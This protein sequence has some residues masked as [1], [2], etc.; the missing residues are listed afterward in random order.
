MVIEH[1][2]LVRKAAAKY[3]GRHYRDWVDDITQD[4]MLKIL[5]NLH[6]F[7]DSKGRIES[8]IYTMTRNLCFDLMDKKANGLGK[9][10]IDENF[11]VLFEDDKAIDYKDVRRLI[12][13]GLDKLPVEDRTILVLRY[14]FDCSGREI[15]S[16]TGIPENQVS[17]RVLRAKE[18][19]KKALER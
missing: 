17:M 19:L 18:K 15:S 12:K 13:D 4:V 10:S 8:W 1:Q 7:D 14:H 2:E 16:Y 6:K 9:I 3:L 11:V 5:Q